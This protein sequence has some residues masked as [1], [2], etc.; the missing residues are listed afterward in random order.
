MKALELL[1]D[2]ASTAMNIKPIHYFISESEL[3]KP[4]I[5]I[6]ADAPSGPIDAQIFCINDFTLVNQTSD[7][8]ASYRDS[9]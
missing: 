7:P 1:Y 8:L 4:V 3:C 9:I 6:H 5:K 2:L